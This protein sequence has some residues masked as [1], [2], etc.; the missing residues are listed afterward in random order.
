MTI[1]AAAATDA[2]IEKAGEDWVLVLPLDGP[3]RTLANGELW[4]DVGNFCGFFAG[5]VFDRSVLSKEN[6]PNTHALSNIELILCG[7]ARGGEKMLSRLRGSFVVAII[8]RARD[9]VIITRD[10]LGSHPLFYTEMGSSVAFAATPQA[11]LELPGVSR[12]LNRAALADH[13]CHRWP[14]PQETFFS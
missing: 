14:N 11:L 3:G 7:Y 4:T 10:P 13:L 6:E 8:D 5:P 9:L 2:P 1:R 12:S